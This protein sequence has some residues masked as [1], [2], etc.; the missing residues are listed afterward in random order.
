MSLLRGE[1]RGLPTSIDPNQLTARPVFGNYSGEIVDEFTAFTS[2]SVAA[3][4]TLLGDSVGTMPLDTFNELGGRYEKLPRPTVF[5]RPND[6]QLMFEFVQQTIITMAL[7]G[8]AFWW[9]PRRGLYPIELRNIHPSKVIVRITPEG[10]RVYKIGKEEF[11]SDV[12]QQI[13]WVQLPN[14]PMSM[15]PLD[16]GP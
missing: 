10:E 12:I 7:H 5:V 3:A 4:V 6:D 8:T 16:I 2:T 14:Q 1:R 11:G 13:N 9:A 15:S